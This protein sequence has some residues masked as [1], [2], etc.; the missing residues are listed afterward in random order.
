[1]HHGF[2]LTEEIPEF[3]LMRAT[4]KEE[5]HA[6]LFHNEFLTSRIPAYDYVDIFGG[7]VIFPR[8]DGDLSWRL[9]VGGGLDQLFSTFSPLC[10]SHKQNLKEM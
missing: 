9:L 5:S 10:H 3:S 7:G 4:E 6:E 8:L 2:R 1:M